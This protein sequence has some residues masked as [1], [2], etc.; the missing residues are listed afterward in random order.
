MR[1][2]KRFCAR[3][4]VATGLMASVVSVFGL[5]A[6]HAQTTAATA[7]GAQAPVR[8]M[9]ID[10]A[11]ATALEQNLDLQVQRINPQ[12]RDLDTSVFQAS[13]TP[14]FVSTLSTSDSRQ[15]STSVLSGAAT[16]I[17]LGQ[18]LANAGVSSLTS[19][20]GGSYDVRWN[21]NRNTTNNQFSTFNPQLTSSVS[22]SYVQPLLR[23]FRIDGTRQQLLVSQKNKEIS[24]VQLLQSIAVTVRNVKNAYYD[25]M[26][27]I[28]NLGVQRQ[29]L[30]LARQ[31]LKDNR[32]RVE[33][34]TM[35]PL[36]IVQ[37]EAEVATR[38]E[39]VILAEA[40]IERAQDTVR[41]LVY[42]PAQP[43]FWSARLEPTETVTFVP[44]TVDVDAAVRNALSQR[45]DITAARKSLEAN[46]VNIRY[47][48]NQ[49]LPDVTAQVNY[50][51]RATG[52][53]QV[54][55][56]RDPATGFPND[57]I[58]SSV[59]RSFFSTLGNTFAGDFP[60]WSL[61]VD[62]AYPLG[63]SSTE[64]QLTR[65]RLQNTQAEKQL[66]VTELQVASQV[67]EFARQVQTNAKRVDATRS[68]RVLAE[69]RLEAEEKK[70]QAGMT[71][72]FFVLQ[73]QRDL[74]LARNSELLAL[75][76]YA[77]SVVNYSAVQQ[78]P[79]F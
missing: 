37:A 43:D 29:S 38:E 70:Y 34:G 35:A 62:I 65:A 5:S 47:F 59:G 77:K 52:G 60:G 23:N 63:R 32:A 67:R 17:T 25:L 20:Y 10:D 39:S 66:A 19:W 75:V 9:S 11:V 15:P 40:A 49:S 8:R 48:Q 13:Y 45:T 44:T 24:D 56:G 27:A 3:M 26:Y 6:V 12:L 57:Q 16:G 55:R 46:D 22:A 31:S 42:N 30:D 41:T 36:D 61:Q 18:S 7:P 2:D 14:N 4:A 69:R 73:A 64:A 28:G 21:N 50:N 72:S 78:A 76:E 68:S 1:F 54:T 71:S 53:L 74:N 51:A 58:L 79:L 33:I